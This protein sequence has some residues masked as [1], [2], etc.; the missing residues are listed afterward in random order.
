MKKISKRAKV[1]IALLIAALMTVGAW[2]AA[3]PGGIVT[4]VGGQGDE[5]TRGAEPKAASYLD[6][7]EK[8]RQESNLQI[9]TTEEQALGNVQAI[10]LGQKPGINMPSM[11]E[12]SPQELREVLKKSPMS[13]DPPIKV[14]VIKPDRTGTRAPGVDFNGPYGGPDTFE[15]DTIHFKVTVDDHALIF[16][17]YELTCDGIWDK[18]T[19]G[20]TTDLE[21]DWTYYDNYYCDIL[22]EAW[23]GISTYTVIYTGNNLGETTSFQ[24]Y[25]F[26]FNW[27]VGWKFESKVNMQ[28]TDLGFYRWYILYDAFLWDASTGAMLARC[29][30]PSG[31][32]AWRWCTLPTAV[33]LVAGKEYI[34]S[35]GVYWYIY[36]INKPADTERV[37]F[38]GVYY[39]AGTSSYPSIYW[40]DYA[41]PVVDFKWREVRTLPI[42]ETDTSFLEVN[43]VAPTVFNPTTVPSVG[44]EGNTVKFTAQ[45][46]DPGLDDTWKVR[47]DFGD[48]VVSDW[49]DVR[50]MA[51]GANVLIYHT[52][53]GDIGAFRTRFINACGSFCLKV[54]EHDAYIK[55]YHLTLDQLLQY[56]VLYVETNYPMPSPAEIGDLLADYADIKGSEGAGGVVM[57]W[58]PF[59]ANSP[60][61]I[62]GRWFDD[63]YNPTPKSGR[64]FGP[65]VGIGTIYVPGHP[66]LDGVSAMT[67]YYHINVQSVTENAIRIVDFTDGRVLA[68]T[69][70]NPVVPNGARAVSLPW[71]AFLA[72]TGDYMKV[73][74]NAVKW[75]SRQPDP[76]PMKMPIQLPYVS[77][78]Y[79]DDNPTTTPEDI[80]PVRVEVMDDDH[81]KLKGG[82]KVYTYDFESGTPWA[83]GWSEVQ[84]W[85]WTRG[86]FYYL[87]SGAAY[88]YWYFDWSQSTHTLRSASLDLSGMD[89]S[90]EVVKVTFKFRHWWEA[91]WPTGW[92][93][94]WVEGSNDNFATSILLAEFHHNNPS[95]ENT[96]RTFDITSWAAGQSDVRIQFRSRWY[97]DWWW[98]V[99]DYYIKAEWGSFINGLGSTTGEVLIQNVPPTAIG[100]PTEGFRT[101]SVP[102]NFAGYQISDPALWEPT[103]WFAYR[104][105][106]DDGTGTPWYYKGSLAPPKLKILVINSLCYSGNSCSEYT[107]LFG[108]MAKLDL[109]DRIDGWNFFNPPQA[110]T[111]NYML[112]YDVIIVA[113]N[114]GWFANPLWNEARR[115]TGNNLADYLDMKRGGVIT[116]MAAID[117]A[118]G[119]DIWQLFG[120][121]ID[122]DYGPFEVE[123]GSFSSTT[124]GVIYEPTHPVMRGVKDV[125]SNFIHGGDYRLT[126][127]A[128]LL[129]D[130]ADGN[131]AFGV[132]EVAS[133]GRDAHWGWFPSY[134]GGKDWLTLARNTLGW[135]IGGI[136]TPEIPAIEHT[137]GDNG[138]YYVDLQII[139]DD[140]GY[141]WDSVNNRP[142]VAYP[143]PVPIEGRYIIPI[144]V[145]NVDPVIQ[146]LGAFVSVELCIRLSGNKGN[147]ATLTIEGSDGYYDSVTASRVPGN[148]AVG[149]LKKATIDLST[150]TKY[151]LSVAYDPT[152][153]DGANPEWIFEA[154]FPDGNI[155][156]LRHTFLSELGYQVWEISNK[157]FKRLAIGKPVSFEA[158]ATDVGSDDLAF[159]WIW[160]DRTPYDIFIYAHP[161]VFYRRADSTNPELLP[162]K[163]PRF[164]KALNEQRSAEVDPIDARNAATHTFDE[165]QMPYFLYVTV[166]VMDD[167]VNDAYPSPYMHPGIDMDF[168]EMDW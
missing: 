163:E 55:G 65:N 98:G 48:G 34:V 168:I 24:W 136:P 28:V 154:K 69:K 112:Q 103:E 138:I 165:S 42:T 94:G 131:S 100:G 113:T 7:L 60:W 16:F 133:G 18:P 66:I 49:T 119:L 155:E 21:F 27:N 54:D 51:G 158:R 70:E 89:M 151:K 50:K 116:T 127:G 149:C 80:Y 61:D 4:K 91:N 63:G 75:A 135:T 95:S 8:E 152:D 104:W 88:Y 10:E 121:Y 73:V 86:Y 145:D 118:Y 117:T 146:E 33:N 82:E 37:A 59:I 150:S 62:E 5:G 76:V 58:G 101:E 29:T 71:V 106:F 31:Y 147:M 38:K 19:T 79:K 68:A 2:T 115:Q 102:F 109:V 3:I 134:Q 132:K 144:S 137:F 126:T 35:A 43:N 25:L 14:E 87:Q 30:P 114:W 159:V 141:V 96:V 22:V 108:P 164:D 124:L 130:W 9:D 13:G 67:A 56:D 140:M 1:S 162:Y 148:P 107:G 32:F 72:A 90:A 92:Q 12:I 78:V 36:G 11:R 120:R 40:Q 23:D 15:G 41:Y 161:G 85:A 157:D 84:G 39:A 139:D 26:W 143:N 44:Q 17:R 156:Q 57:G 110:P 52:L 97:D 77:H 74:I 125:Y 153:D 111:L 46:N 105:D 93:D 53:A 167:D 20:W 160:G 6:W 81:G 128:V 166:I 99:D 47:W 122:E 129:A 142:V 45:F 123:E 83:P 64:M